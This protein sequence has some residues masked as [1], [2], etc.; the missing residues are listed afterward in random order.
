MNRCSSH[1]R[2]DRNMNAGDDAVSYHCFC[3]PQWT[4]AACDAMAHSGLVANSLIVISILT[5]VIG[6]CCIPFMK[7]YWQE[8]EKQRYQEIIQGD[9]DLRDQLEKMG[10]PPSVIR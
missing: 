5:F 1:G 9:D 7:E 10:I 4:G 6:L 8:Q 3:E 2:C